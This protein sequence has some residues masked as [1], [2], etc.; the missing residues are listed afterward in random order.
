MAD[1]HQA[2]GVQSKRMPSNPCVTQGL[3]KVV[4]RHKSRGRGLWAAVE[5]QAYIYVMEVYAHKH[6]LVLIAVVILS[7]GATTSFKLSPERIVFQT[8]HGDIEM[9]LYPEVIKG[10]LTMCRAAPS[11]AECA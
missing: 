5:W 6:L 4:N 7:C 9:A 11:P 8:K 1:T 10:T 2:S 3:E